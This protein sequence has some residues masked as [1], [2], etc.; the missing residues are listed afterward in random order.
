MFFAMTGPDV[1]KGCCLRD[2]GRSLAV[3]PQYVQWTESDSP[4]RLDFRTE[5]VARNGWSLALGSEDRDG[6]WIVRGGSLPPAR[7]SVNVRVGWQKACV[8]FGRAPECGV[9]LHFD[10]DMQLMVSGYGL[11][12]TGIID[13]RLKLVQNGPRGSTGHAEDDLSSEQARQSS[14]ACKYAQP[15]PGLGNG[16][17]P[18]PPD[19][20]RPS[21][22]CK[23]VA[24][25]Q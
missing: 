6:P 11:F 20:R 19:H 10:D 18:R 4:L 25:R 15:F 14:C 5:D 13:D 9:D 21:S 8:L 3:L 7:T 17:Y 22:T 23:P 1:P 24:G 12:A 16:M 2:G